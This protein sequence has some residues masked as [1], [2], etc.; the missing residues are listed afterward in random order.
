MRDVPS[1]VGRRPSATIPDR[2]VRVLHAGSRSEIFVKM[3]EYPYPKS[4]GDGT[5]FV[6]ILD[7]FF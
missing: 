7:K 3:V 4:S 5:M 6:L 2:G 1:Q